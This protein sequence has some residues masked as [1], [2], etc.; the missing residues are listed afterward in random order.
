M[1]KKSKF[2]IEDNRWIV[3]AF[4]VKSPLW[5]LSYAIPVAIFWGWVGLQSQFN[6]AEAL[7]GLFLGAFLW[8]TFEY[9]V[10]RYL[11]HFVPKS[12]SL[13][14]RFARSFHIY[15]HV[16][17]EDRGV[18]TAGWGLALFWHSVMGG[19]MYVLLPNL[20]MLGASMLALTLYHQY[21]EWIHYLVHQK[22]YKSGHLQYLQQYHLRH[23][24]NWKV[25]FGQTT[26]LMDRIAGTYEPV[27]SESKLSKEHIFRNLK[28]TI[29]FSGAEVLHD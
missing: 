1:S 17:P 6:L 26:S 21:Y 5:A 20:L 25:N 23:H 16:Q 7:M 9:C 11:Y 19:M 12:N 22:E 13:I 28:K 27:S 24:K 8:L 3:F 4:A 29:S 15:H 14:A 2:L 18:I 10:H